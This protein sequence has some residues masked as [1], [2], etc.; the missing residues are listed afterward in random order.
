MCSFAIFALLAESASC[1][2]PSCTLHSHAHAQLYPRIVIAGPEEVQDCT[3]STFELD[4]WISNG[5]YG[6]AWA[7]IAWIIPSGLTFS[8][9][10]NQMVLS[11][12]TNL[13]VAGNTYTFTLRL[14][15]AIG[16]TVI[17]THDVRRVDLLRPTI[18]LE[19]GPIRRVYAG[20]MTEIMVT[21]SAPS[22][23]GSGTCA[24]S[25]TDPVYYMWAY[26]KV[27]EPDTAYVNLAYPSGSGTAG[28]N[29]TVSTQVMGRD[30]TIGSK[31]WYTQANVHAADLKMAN[32]IYVPPGTLEYGK[33]YHFKS[34]VCL[35]TTGATS[36][37]LCAERVLMVHVAK[38]PPVALVKGGSFRY[39]PWGEKLILDGSMSYHPD[40]PL[41][42]PQK[43]V[44]GEWP[45][46]TNFTWTCARVTDAG[47]VPCIDLQ[48]ADS[49]VFYS[50]RNPTD[51]K[52]IVPANIFPFDTTFVFRLLVTHLGATGMVETRVQIVNAI[53]PRVTIIRPVNMKV[54]RDDEIVLE[55]AV[56]GDY[57]S[58][59]WTIADASGDL[60][61]NGKLN[62]ALT[63]TTVMNT[64]IIVFKA[65]RLHDGAFY[66]FRMYAVKGNNTVVG[67][68]EAGLQVNKP[69]FGGILA[70][71]PETVSPVKDLLVLNALSWSDDP[72]DY[73]LTYNF[74]LRSSNP[75]D[76]R[77]PL[78]VGVRT[79][80][81]KTVPIPNQGYLA[82]RDASIEV[83]V[84]DRH[85]AKG[86]AAKAIKINALDLASN[87]YSHYKSYMVTNYN[88]V[89]A[90]SSLDRKFMAIN[91]NV[92]LMNERVVIGGGDEAEKATL[93][94]DRL[95]FMN[96]L[97]DVIL[98]EG[99]RVM[100]TEAK[101]EQFTRMLESI[102]V[103]PDEFQD[104]A[105]Q[106]KVLTLI[107]NMLASCK[108]NGI[109]LD[110]LNAGSLV[111]TIGRA[112]EILT[113]QTAPAPAPTAPP[114]LAPTPSPGSRRRRLNEGDTT[115][116][117]PVVVP[118]ADHPTGFQFTL[119]QRA[120]ME[121]LV[122]Q[123]CAQ[124]ME[125]REVGMN[126]LYYST[127]YF[128][129]VCGKVKSEM[130]T[131]KMGV[132]K[133]KKP[134]HI[135]LDAPADLTVAE[136]YTIPRNVTPGKR[137]NN[138]T[139]PTGIVSGRNYDVFNTM[140]P[141]SF[142]YQAMQWNKYPFA[143][144]VMK[145]EQ[146]QNVAEEYA[147]SKRLTETFELK[148]LC[149]TTDGN[150]VP[151]PFADAVEPL[152]VR[153]ESRESTD[154]GTD[155]LST[156]LLP[157]CFYRSG[158]NWSD[159]NMSLSRTFNE[160]T[161]NW[162]R[163]YTTNYVECSAQH[164]QTAESKA[165]MFLAY[166]V[167]WPVAYRR[168]STTPLAIT[169]SIFLCYLFLG[170]LGSVVD[171][172]YIKSYQAKSSEE[173]ALLLEKGNEKTKLTGLALYYENFKDDHVMFSLF[174]GGEGAHDQTGYDEDFDRFERVTCIFFS[175]AGTY[176]LVG[177]QFRGLQ[178]DADAFATCSVP[179]SVV[180]SKAITASLLAIPTVDLIE[181][182][183]RIFYTRAEHSAGEG[184]VARENE[185][186]AEL[187]DLKQELRVKRKASQAEIHASLDPGQAPKPVTRAAMNQLALTEML[188]GRIQEQERKMKRHLPYWTMYLTI[189]IPALTFILVIFLSIVPF[190]KKGWTDC[191]IG[192]Y[193]NCVPQILKV[194]TGLYRARGGAQG[195]ARARALLSSFP[196]GGGGSFLSTLW[197]CPVMLFYAQLCDEKRAHLLL[198]SSL[199]LL[200]PTLLCPASP[201]LRR[202]T[203]NPPAC[204]C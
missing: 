67:W 112:N 78:A 175:I 106:A 105:M 53:V 138:A 164:F 117:A 32:R 2:A 87:G 44:N 28:A 151:V 181:E 137:M 8:G 130:V 157:Q 167:S 71:T 1:V 62:S 93:V 31:H 190:I 9:T 3:G 76:R 109:P 148:V 195:R 173:Q 12:P 140:C 92:Q 135:Y 15:N 75:Y 143:V 154:I 73:P 26:K 113:G 59:Y 163:K 98:R 166:E 159:Y 24:C 51:V 149:S 14:R 50:I 145:S 23:C 114:I 125:A 185:Q 22:G 139:I 54:N 99:D 136:D 7:E 5:I 141:R 196:G 171:D 176:L 122:D 162:D 189:A 13:L 119:A 161:L 177:M 147:V 64:P 179:S 25:I 27:T 88:D 187:K 10:T 111:H 188:L 182:F 56:T 61:V 134:I 43:D 11:M 39:Q 81:L 16:V 178:C 41:W 94:A 170:V 103:H 80:K 144:N 72:E 174:L 129:F 82:A 69:P 21:A 116:S 4:G 65:N 193:A 79:Y 201:S 17:K 30:V 146:L 77:E 115:T 52:L 199:A 155:F 186:I 84:I 86:R 123:L 104:N 100:K 57:D 49:S 158:D 18:L 91:A 153:I 83:E 74:W 38:Q 150:L 60:L 184:L 202:P 160:A 40:D 120:Q 34:I 168:S 127:A 90:D 45:T 156:Q 198:P 204:T 118:G 66:K 172:W 142:N 192:H 55:G 95:S 102:M 183:L 35:E 33:D 126:P 42:V 89:V 128:K 68:S 200:F 20:D 48:A 108:R 131:T 110:T 203:S 101:L 97:H 197:L 165:N 191:D 70:V 194:R 29:G 85:G 132:R 58:T 63:R 96:L 180:F 121:V 133:L 46:G 6:Q 47:E 124:Q 169:V 19:E 107:Q 37:K 152:Q 36:T